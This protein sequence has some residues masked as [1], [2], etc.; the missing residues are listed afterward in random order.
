VS[1]LWPK[2]GIVRVDAEGEPDI[3][4]VVE[5]LEHPV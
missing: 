3:D 4:R 1:R 5:S 2:P